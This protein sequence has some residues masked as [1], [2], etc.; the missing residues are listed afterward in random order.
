MNRLHN[1]HKNTNKKRTCKSN[2]GTRK[3]LK[4]YGFRRGLSNKKGG[5]KGCLSCFSCFSKRTGPHSKSNTAK[6]N[7]EIKQLYIYTIY[8]GILFHRTGVDQYLLKFNEYKNT[9]ISHIAYL[10]TGEQILSEK[11]QMSKQ[12]I[13]NVPRNVTDLEWALGTT[14]GSIRSQLEG[15]NDDNTELIR[16]DWQTVKN[17]AEQ[18]QQHPFEHLN[19]LLNKYTVLF[20]SPFDK[21]LPV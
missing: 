10:T 1:K 18:D 16:T 21:T 13:Q 12:Q 5:S 19:A 3:T 17:T 8:Y 11:E 9:L 4:S 2:K 6:I 15:V 14:Q 20:R 7:N